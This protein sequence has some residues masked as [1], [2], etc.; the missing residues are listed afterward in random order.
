MRGMCNLFIFV[1]ERGE[2]RVFVE[3]VPGVVLETDPVV[4]QGVG[5]LQVRVLA[6]ETSR[7]QRVGHLLLQHRP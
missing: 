5:A 1:S 4:L 3:A 7:H 6:V 2:V